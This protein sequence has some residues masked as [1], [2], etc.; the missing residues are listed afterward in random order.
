MEKALLLLIGIF[1][2][3]V[4][5]VSAQDQMNV[6][7]SM[8]NSGGIPMIYLHVSVIAV[9]IVAIAAGWKSAKAN[10]QI[11]FILAGVAVF[12][13]LH[14]AELLTNESLPAMDLID[15][16]FQFVGIV[17]IG[18]GLYKLKK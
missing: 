3:S 11:Y 18:F 13:L 5:S 15:H 6:G 9:S 14:L 17:L 7:S 2:V 4:V 10:K 12:G 16:A 1:L 8:M